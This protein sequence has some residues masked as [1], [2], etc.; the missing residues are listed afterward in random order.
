M[1]YL[2]HIQTYT[3]THSHMHTHTLLHLILS[4]S[5]RSNTHTLQS[6]VYWKGLETIINPGA[7]PIACC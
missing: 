5:P 6:S 2:K 4:K 1:F 7:T 3:R